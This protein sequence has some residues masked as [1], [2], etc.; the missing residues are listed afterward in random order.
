MSFVFGI[1]ADNP[2][3]RVKI[4]STFVSATLGVSAQIPVIQNLQRCSNTCTETQEQH[5]WLSERSTRIR[6]SGGCTF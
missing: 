1:T 4:S 5:G 3:D 6:G 2:N